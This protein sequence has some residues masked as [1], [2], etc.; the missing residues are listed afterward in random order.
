MD[1]KF[2]YILLALIFETSF[3][4]NLTTPQLLGEQKFLYLF[5]VFVL[6]YFSR[7]ESK[8]KGLLFLLSSDSNSLQN[9]N[10][11]SYSK[12]KNINQRN[13]NNNIGLNKY[14]N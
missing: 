7:I 11:I 10:K 3:G 12:K 14:F 2:T 5:L 8:K 4:I 1:H 13:E 6:F 9:F